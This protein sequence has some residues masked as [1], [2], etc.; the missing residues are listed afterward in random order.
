MIKFSMG[1]T[2]LRYQEEYFQYGIDNDPE[3]R[4]L[5]I[6]LLDAAFNADLVAAYLLDITE[7][8]FIM[9]IFFSQYQDNGEVVFD[10]IFSEE[11]IETGYIIF[12]NTSTKKWEIKNQINNGDLGTRRLL[13]LSYT[14]IGGDRQQSLCI[15]QQ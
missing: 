6:L 5:I 7:N 9:T 8:N 11:V 3:G 15:S 14:G 10:E 12:K 1:N 4:L 13:A 2:V